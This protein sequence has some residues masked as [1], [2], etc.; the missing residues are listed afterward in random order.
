M[1]R[2]VRRGSG[3]AGMRFPERSAQGVGSSTW[4]DAG[5]PG[6]HEAIVETS[7]PATRSAMGSG[8]REA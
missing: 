6:E 1:D 3:L 5:R 2:Q 7:M 8:A 4:R